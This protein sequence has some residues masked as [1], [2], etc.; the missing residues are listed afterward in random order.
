MTDST[1]TELRR[2]SF[3]YMDRTGQQLFMYTARPDSTKQYVFNN[4]TFTSPSKALSY[5]NEMLAE[6]QERPVPVLVDVQLFGEKTELATRVFRHDTY[7]HSAALLVSGTIVEAVTTIT[8]ED[9]MK[10]A[11]DKRKEYGG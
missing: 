9:A 11:A 1:V 6:A 10:W 2:I 8:K 3:M 4:K 7:S 5:A